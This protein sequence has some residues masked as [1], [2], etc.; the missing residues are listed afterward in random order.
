MS[1][2]PRF[3][4]PRFGTDGVRGRAGEPPMDAETLRRI[5][6]ALGVWL[7]REGGADKKVLIGNDGR[8]SAEWIL[9]ALVGGLNATEVT[10]I[11]VGLLTTPALAY[12]TRREPVQA[13]IMISASHNPADDNGIKIFGHDGAKLP[14]AAEREIEQL[15]ETVS[16]TPGDRLRVKPRR[17]LTDHYLEHL[18]NL[19]PALDLGGRRVVLDAA[20]GGGSRL[21]PALLRGFGAEVIEVGCAPDGHNINAG[22]G[23]LHPGHVARAVL[24]NHARLGISLDGDGDRGIFVD[25]TGTVRDGD[26]VMMVLAIDR[27]R[28]GQ[29]PGN[30]LVATV[31]SNLG[32]HHA[33]RRHGITVVVTPVG[34][35]AVVQAMRAGGYGLGGEQSGHIVFAGDAAYTGD[36]L[37]TALQLLSLPGAL[38][39]GLARLFSEFR[40]YPQVLINVQVAR[41]PPLDQV[42]AV[43]TAIQAVETA[44]AGDGRVLLRY[45]G[46]E[47]LCRVM[48]EGQD[49]ATVQAHAERLAA[50]VR[51]AL[52]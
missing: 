24:A 12:L 34:D 30:T 37:Y 3:Q 19:F 44:L 32:L 40:R 17:E 18:A 45:S 43:Q 42:P 6:A 51:E 29:L 15:T 36:G 21:G 39:D 49:A 47:R 9:A 50:A 48:V 27:M 22:V 23:A 20:H 10:A 28:R 31:M 4:P 1:E 2:A 14:D 41:K 52:A 8:A 7:Q 46:T 13:G 25:E 35:R 5:G 33:L 26:E 11:D 16:F 38:Q